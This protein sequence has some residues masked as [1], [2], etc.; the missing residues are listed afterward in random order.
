[1][2]HFKTELQATAFEIQTRAAE[3]AKITVSE[4]ASLIDFKNYKA[5]VYKYL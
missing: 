5:E 1:L 4:H 2:A 3:Q